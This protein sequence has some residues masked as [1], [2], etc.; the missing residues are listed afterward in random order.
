[1]LSCHA[2]PSAS[3]AS[4]CAARRAQLGDGAAVEVDGACRAFG[5]LVVLGL[6]AVR[7]R[8]DG[9]SDR[10]GARCQVDLAPP[11]TED[12]RATH[13]GGGEH[14]PQGVQLV[15]AGAA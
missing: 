7:G 8:Q 9:L 15:L 11:Q 3:F 4:F 1:L 6:E 12:L 2:D 5:L 14:A 13:P 10:Q